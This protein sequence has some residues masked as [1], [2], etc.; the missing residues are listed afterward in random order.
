MTTIGGHEALKRITD[1]FLPYSEEIYSS[2]E[3]MVDSGIEALIEPEIELAK[4]YLD[5]LLSGK[6]SEAELR[7]L[8]RTLGCVQIPFIDDD[9]EQSCTEFLRFIRSRFDAADKKGK[10][11]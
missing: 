9:D 5:E 6:H 11:W 4:D 1:W 10:A 3:E 2:L 7:V 8:W